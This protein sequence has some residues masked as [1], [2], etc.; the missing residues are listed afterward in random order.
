MYKIIE[1]DNFNGDYPDEKQLCWVDSEGKTTIITLNHL[2][3]EY[4]T[5]VLNEVTGN[6]IQS[7]RWIITKPPTYKLIPGFEP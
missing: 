2:Q 1:T 5:S 6:S 7:A 3:A 4:L